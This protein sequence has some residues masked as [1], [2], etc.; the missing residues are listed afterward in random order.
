MR[1]T[2]EEIDKWIAKKGR[3]LAFTLVQCGIFLKDGNVKLFYQFAGQ[4]VDADVVNKTYDKIVYF[5]DDMK[6]FTRD[7]ITKEELMTLIE[8]EIAAI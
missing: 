6:A 7:E 8:K 5:T 4:G 1:P 2:H 3:W